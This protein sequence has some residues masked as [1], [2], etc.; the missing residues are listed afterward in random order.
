M[1]VI[2]WKLDH[3]THYDKWPSDF[4]RN[5]NHAKLDRSTHYD[6]WP[7][8]FSR[9]SN[10]AVIQYKHQC[11]FCFKEWLH[12]QPYT[13]ILFYEFHLKIYSCLNS[14]PMIITFLLTLRTF[15]LSFLWVYLRQ[16]SF[17]IGIW[18]LILCK[19]QLKLVV[20]SN[21]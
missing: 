3:S 20:K 18:E 19:F 15:N 17:L 16:K 2:S 21:L 8:D 7:S 10:H 13:F 14:G 9:N 5:S 1:A 6:K 4:S 11:L 12:I